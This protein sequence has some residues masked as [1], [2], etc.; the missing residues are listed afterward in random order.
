MQFFSYTVGSAIGILPGTVLFVLLG[1]LASSITEVINGDLDT[2][3][4]VLFST[5]AVSIVVMVIVVVLLT[6]YAKKALREQT[7]KAEAEQAA[8]A[9]GEG[10]AMP[11]E[12]D[13][14][15]ATSEHG[16][17]TKPKDEVVVVVNPLAEGADSDE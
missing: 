15:A 12:V 7:E 2:S 16:G 17:S 14:S 1:T 13:V 4:A 5:I 9:A 6:R 11:S 8:A 3:P 10:E